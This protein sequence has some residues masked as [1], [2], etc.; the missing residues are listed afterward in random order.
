MDFRFVKM[1]RTTNGSPNGVLICEYLAGNI[2][3]LPIDLAAVF[4]EKMNVAVYFVEESKAAKVEDI[5][6]GPTETR[7]S[8]KAK[9]K[10]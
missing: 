5:K 9:R 8:T 1:L 7:P 4:V 3:E 10:G 2:Y 6:I